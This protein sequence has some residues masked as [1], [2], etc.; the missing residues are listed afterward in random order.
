M[1]ERQQKPYNIISCYPKEEDTNKLRNFPKLTLENRLIERGSYHSFKEEKFWWLINYWMYTRN[2]RKYSLSPTVSVALIVMLESLSISVLRMMMAI[3]GLVVSP[4]SNQISVYFSKFESLA[5]LIEIIFFKKP[6]M[7]SLEIVL[8][9][10]IEDLWYLLGLFMIF[11]AIKM[12][13][14]IFASC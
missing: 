2:S 9:S 4:L 8:R 1:Y 7:L 6:C 5:G 13:V 11:L 12:T 3:L 14:W 10:F